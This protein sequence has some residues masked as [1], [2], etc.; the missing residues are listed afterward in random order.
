MFRRWFRTGRRGLETA[1]HAHFIDLLVS[2]IVDWRTW[3]LTLGLWFVSLFPLSALRDWTPLTIFLISLGIAAAVA[4]V[5]IA[6]RLAIAVRHVR[7]AVQREAVAADTVAADAGIPAPERQLDILFNEDDTAFVR[8]RKGLYGTTRTR[9]WWVGIHNASRTRSIDDISLRARE[10]QFVDCTIAIAHQHPGRLT[11][12][13]PIIA[14][15]RTLPPG[16]TEMVEL[17]GLGADEYSEQDILSKRQRFTLELRARDTP[18]VQFV[19]EYDPSTKPPI[20]RR[21]GVG[22]R[23]ISLF[24]A[25]TRAYEHTQNAIVS[26]FSEA[27]ANGPDEI[28]T[29]YCEA[30]TRYRDG[31]Q[32]LVQMWGIRPPSRIREEIYMAPL[33][34]YGFQVEGTE[35][36]LQSRT[37]SGRYERLMVDEREVANAIKEI[38]TWG[39]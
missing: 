32:P 28:L 38:A 16:A 9:R 39:G 33:N 21:A 20:I 2:W 31:K 30:M 11:E 8:D 17:F 15:L 37:G 13:E 23:F 22:S 19:L 26:A 12:R 27:F 3:A 10:G 35:I 6:I 24:E 7:R 34:N 1:E 29:W 36:V 4:L 18:V 14:E 25:A 5:Y